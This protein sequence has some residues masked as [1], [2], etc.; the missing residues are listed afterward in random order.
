MY[1][2]HDGGPYPRE[3]CPLIC[4]SNEWTAFYMKEISA[5]KELKASLFALVIIMKVIHRFFCRRMGQ[6]N[7]KNIRKLL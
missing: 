7:F 6:E 5:K 4:F 1:L 2:F 3:T